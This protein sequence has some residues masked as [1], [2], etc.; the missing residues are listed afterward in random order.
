MRYKHPLADAL[1]RAVREH[2]RRMEHPVNTAKEAKARYAVEVAYQ[3][4]VRHLPGA[5]P[6]P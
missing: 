3:A 2:E 5:E 4:L 1:V 6:L